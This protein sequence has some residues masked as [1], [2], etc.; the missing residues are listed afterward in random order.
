MRTKDCLIALHGIAISGLLILCACGG[1]S[2]SEIST[3]GG[4]EP[5]PTPPP[6]PTPTPSC[7]LNRI[8]S[9]SFNVLD[10]GAKGNWVA[11]DTAA[12]QAAVDAAAGTDGRVLIPKGTYMVNALTS[13]V[14]RSHMTLQLDPEAIL[15]A[16]SASYNQTNY[17]ILLARGVDYVNIIGG[18]L[19]GDFRNGHT[20]TTGQ[21]GHGLAIIKDN[22]NNRST[23][24]VVK[25]VKSQ[26]CWG[27][28]F[29]VSGYSEDILFCNIRA[30]NNRRAGL[31]VTDA[32]RM[33]VVGSTF[34]T[35]QG[36]TESAVFKCGSGMDIE[37]N[38]YETVNALTVTDCIFTGNA[39]SGISAGKKE[40]GTTMS[41]IVIE[42]NTVTGNGTN[43]VSATRGIWITDGAS[44][45][46]IQNNTVRNNWGIGIHLVSNANSSFVTGN[47]VTGTLTK[48]N[49]Q[50]YGGGEGI[51]LDSTSGN[52]ITGNT[53]TGNEGCGIR[54]AYPTG[55]NTI[56]GNANT[57]NGGP[58]S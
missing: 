58:C 44:G 11:D 27:D 9:S 35:A 2:G 4:G 51:L 19:K 31:S 40:A 57:D 33:A 10:Y 8:S 52:H 7:V 14:L 20:G 17:A 23:H 48:S 28:G 45:F 56:S 6:P 30:E 1:G 47:T 39:G 49:P 16:N 37:P 5:T 22:S 46:K 29:Y 32:N 26:Y 38:A 18:T 24:I 54:D 12:I 36:F 53:V 41:G 42:G 3:S 13:I 50:A 55:T 43:A 15:K 34:N 25:D 21:W